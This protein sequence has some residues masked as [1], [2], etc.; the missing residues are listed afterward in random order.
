MRKKLL[1]ITFYILSWNALVTGSKF[2]SKIFKKKQKKPC[3]EETL[4]NLLAE[5]QVI[6]PEAI[7]N[8]STME[9]VKPLCK[10]VS[11]NLEKI[12]EILAD[13]KPPHQ[14]DLYFQ[15][16][17]GEEILYRKLCTESAFKQQ[18]QGHFSCFHK[19]RSEFDK[20]NGTPDWI[21]NSDPEVICAEYKKISNCYY[22][23]TGTHCGQEAAEV[24]KELV[25][26]IINSIL[27]IKCDINEIGTNPEDALE[28]EAGPEG[29]KSLKT[30]LLDKLKDK[31]DIKSRA[32]Q[33][34]NYISYEVLLVV[35]TNFIHYTM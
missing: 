28:L 15:L 24:M 13:C 34:K 26:S 20:C 30:K 16:I 3:D 7:I 4:V 14:P 22:E 19:F 33:K 5:I 18:F 32:E 31:K 2:Y 12:E 23:I 1:L 25:I 27:T 6:N 29:K 17:K 21:E 8:L 10:K 9:E 11:E 35:L